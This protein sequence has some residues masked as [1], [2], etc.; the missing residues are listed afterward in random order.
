MSSRYFSL[1][2]ANEALHTIKPLM[3][4][5]QEIRSRILARR[6]EIWPAL[7]RAAGNGGNAAL[8][9]MVGEFD[10][11]NELVHGV[12][13]TGAQIKDLGTGLLDFPAQRHGRDVLLCWK[14][15]EPSVL[16][17]HELDAG[18]AGRRPIS[19]L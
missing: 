13:D 10:R 16:Y 19:E 4:Q 6:P 8:S 9:E 12:L 18:F 11:L 7:A 5:I 15:G 3:Y 2:E 1:D 14:H 17:W